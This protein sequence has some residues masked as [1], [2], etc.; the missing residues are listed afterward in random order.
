MRFIVFICLMSAGLACANVGPPNSGGRAAGEPL[1]IRDVAIEHE[2]L[3]IDLRPLAD[4]GSVRVEAT[5]QL[6]NSGPEQRL[7]LLFAAASNVENF[8][9]T[10]DGEPLAAAPVPKRAIPETWRYPQSTPPIPGRGNNAELRFQP[11]ATSAIGFVAVI[12]PGRHTLTA[13]YQG[14]AGTHLY[15]DPT[16]YR[17]FGYTLAPARAWA[18]FG[19]LDV[20]VQVPAGWY[21]AAAPHLDRE[22]DTL[23]GQFDSVPAD[24]LT[25]TVQAPE[26][27]AYKPVTYSTLALLALTVLLGLIGSWW[28]GRRLGRRTARQESSGFWRQHAFPWTILWGLSW[29][30]AILA[31]GLLATFAP[32]AALPSGQASHYGYG[33]AFAVIG[34]VVLS[35]LLAPIGFAIAQVTAVA[36]A[37]AA[38]RDGLL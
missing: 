18:G 17:Q 11:K 37:G 34:V 30:A 31:A 6:N 28:L 19:N 21:A 15:G 8:R 22:G 35:A 1:G 2:N 10:L 9:I 3:S 27:A 36:V 7:H 16:V 38:R 25:I 20:T 29:G 32:D 33:P 12:P 4:G 24:F 5:Y 26:G 13:S 23:R 14:E